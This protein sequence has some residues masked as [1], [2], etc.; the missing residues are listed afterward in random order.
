MNKLSLVTFHLDM[1]NYVF[2]RVLQDLIHLFKAL[3][4]L[5]SFLSLPSDI[6]PHR[7]Q[8][9]QPHLNIISHSS[10]YLELVGQCVEA[11]I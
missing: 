3:V 2:S 10:L 9:F 4:L 11:G 7:L 1:Q 6:L 5:S 8:S